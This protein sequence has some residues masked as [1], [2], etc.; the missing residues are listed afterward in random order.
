MVHR[1]KIKYYLAF[2]A[3]LLTFLVYLPAL[4]ND[5][6]N[7]DD[8]Q[9]I[10]E[11]L[12]IRSFD[13][14]FFRWAFFDFYAANWHPLT[15]ISHAL[16]YAIWGLNPLGHHLTNNILHAA[17]TFV[18][19]LLA[20][21]LMEGCR[22]AINYKISPN[23][24]F[25]KRGPALTPTLEKGDGGGFSDKKI[26][27]TAGVT[28]LLFGLHPLHVESVAWVAERKDLLCA[29][30]Y[31]LSIMEYM[32]YAGSITPPS[33]S[34]LKRGW[35][36]RGRYLLSLSFFILA[37]LSKPMAVSLPVVLLI[38]DWY[39]LQRIRSLKTLL[40]AVMEKLPFVTLSLFSS[41]L[42]FMAQRSGGAM[43]LIRP[44]TLPT[45]LL[46]AVKSLVVYL[47]KM[48]M[49]INLSP[50][51]LYPKNVSLLSPEY[52]LPIVL[53]AG[54]TVGCVVAAR[55]QKLWLSCWGYYLI[56][57]IPVLGI[58]QVGYQAMAD[59]YTYLPALGP[60]MLAG[61]STAWLFT[62]MG[63]SKKHGFMIN[64]FG[65]AAALVVLASLSYV[66]LK[67]IR[68]WKNS[69]V[70]W[71]YVIEKEPL[72]TDIV[73]DNRGSAF[74]DTGQFDRAIEDFSKA[75]VL[76]PSFALAYSN[77]GS[78][79]INMGRLDRAVE[80]FDMAITLEPSASAYYSRGMVFERLGLPDRAI[81]D[82]LQAIALKPSYGS[83]YFSLGVLYGMSGAIDKAIYCFDK[84]IG[85]IPNHS[86]A[87]G[88]RGLAYSM[89]GR[90]DKAL[91]DLDRAIELNKG[92]AEAYGNR[93]NVYLKTGQKEFAIRDFEKACG[94]GDKE[95]CNVMS[96]L[97]P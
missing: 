86:L 37:L 24:S 62:T 75:I 42:T 22:Q 6:V 35:R 31:L 94:L 7:W 83:A 20:A 66:T 19:V 64:I 85:I 73:Y 14:T 60:F 34:Y 32:K 51:Y 55:R 48:I 46:V 45:R 49:P 92:Y 18:V 36:S 63:A 4:Q 67:Q 52:F 13:L 68:I 93:G 71:T 77:R 40:A 25:P 29:F 95:A 8:S 58:V 91:K 23:P 74:N 89:I 82:Y 3:S 81:A 56:T 1:T 69:I 47:W 30:F 76:N 61:L 54:I 21:R 72:S 43:E 53:V 87:Y 97:Q 78:A 28:G 9:Y 65:A 41:V 39:P 15:W 17:N 96:R 59:R 10:Y 27:I 44:E 88:N 84:T 11:N 16:D 33:P 80:D 5:F 50:L 70:L 12:Q 79:F 57:L 26:L 38:L 90:Y 2:A